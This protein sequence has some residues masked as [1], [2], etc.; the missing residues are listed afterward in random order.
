MPRQGLKSPD[1]E[2]A[3][4]GRRVAW[5]SLLL[6]LGTFALFARTASHGFIAYDDP[7]YVTGNRT[8]QDGLT[9]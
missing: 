3:P 9:W 2:P 1:P 4:G 6:F 5:L 7:G 8:V